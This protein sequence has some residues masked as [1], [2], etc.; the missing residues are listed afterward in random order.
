MGALD[1]AHVKVGIED[2]SRRALGI[3][4]VRVCNIG[5]VLLGFGF[6]S[7]MEGRGNGGFIYMGLISYSKTQ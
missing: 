3:F 1:Q 2:A 6:W 4:I 5:I 7:W